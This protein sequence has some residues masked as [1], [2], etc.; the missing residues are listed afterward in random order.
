MQTRKN[1]IR[2][3]SGGVMLEESRGLFRREGSKVL[4]AFLILALVL[5]SNVQLASANAVL[6]IT[7]ITWSSVGLNNTS[8]DLGPNEY[9]A[10]VRVCNTGDAAADNLSVAFIWETES[11]Y[12]ELA[13]P[14][15]YM[16]PELEAETCRDFYFYIR[17]MQDESSVGAARRY[18]IEAD[19]D[20][21]GKVLT[22]TPR[23][24]YVESLVPSTDMTSFS[25]EGPEIVAVGDLIEYSVESDL[26]VD[27]Y[28][29]VQYLNFPP[30]MF[31]LVSVETTF[32]SHPAIIHDK[33]YADACGWQD[34]PTNPDYRTC[35][36]PPEFPGGTVSGIVS[37]IYTV[38]VLSAG[39]A[40]VTNT[41]YGYNGESFS[42]NQDYGQ[43][44]L[45]ITAQDPTPTPTQTATN[46]GT[47]DVTDTIT[48]TLTFSPTLTS[49][50][51]ITPTPSP[52]NTPTITP[53]P[54]FTG[55]I[56][57]V[58]GAGKT[59][60]GG[61]ELRLNN[62]ITFNIRVVNTGTAPADNVVLTDN[63]TAFGYLNIDNLETTKGTRNI[64]ARIATV[65]I[66]T[67]MP[68]EVVT[69]TLTLR[70]TST[71][72]TTQNPCNTATVS[73]GATGRVT[74]NQACFRVIGG[75]V[76][77]GTGEHV[78]FL[79][80]GEPISLP[81]LTVLFA[82]MAAGLVTAAWWVRNSRK[83]LFT[84]GVLLFAVSM[85][86]IFSLQDDFSGEQSPGISAHIDIEPG[87]VREASATPTLNPF[88]VHPT[89]EF[90]EFEIVETLPAFTIPDPV[91]TTTPVPG[92][93]EPDTSPVRRIRIPSLAVD[94]PVAYVPFEDS[95]WLIQGLRE[96]IAWMG[97][98]SW[99]GLGGNTGLAGHVTV[100]GLG[101]GPFW[102][103]NTLSQG[104]SIAL[105]TEENVY[106]YSVRDQRIVE[107]W[108][109]S[110][111]E[112]T[113]NPQITLITC[114]DWDEQERVY[115]KR[116][117]VFADLLRVE[118]LSTA[119]GY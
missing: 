101:K 102:D 43:T 37:T 56:R 26:T 111:L 63:L 108:D 50:P 64:D 7:S 89:Y 18:R 45:V 66:G 112:P 79:D 62:T 32:S 72:A 6:E 95:T 67:M 78:E 31:R 76:L 46:T 85:G 13:G 41:L 16:L 82:L 86:L 107:E 4:L 61:T 24:I 42:Y 81:W 29:F 12:I 22:P 87:T 74:T 1:R 9:P 88:S 11:D 110:V 98:T 30:D 2:S 17:V 96:E 118:S 35:V 14:E 80:T 28:Q 93:P 103:L 71:P 97:D 23:E 47:P 40:V 109:L 68:N 106:F 53:T 70:V 20:Q 84:I 83:N 94:N 36:G 33:I 73:F 90:S 54:T 21:T 3:V 113:S 49:T 119:R 58:M 116:L 105:Y 48:P 75:P 55:T 27:F 51:T 5:N 60:V 52:T 19:S 104:A 65:D 8:P 115:L 117:V 39:S 100:R 91:L 99:P 59:P 57:P 77:P 69:V 15:S 34:D 10:G 25:I 92:Q 38:E 44:T 114:V